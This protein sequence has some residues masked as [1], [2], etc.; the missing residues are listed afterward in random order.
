MEKQ[1]ESKIEEKVPK[2][3]HRS[4]QHYLIDYHEICKILCQCHSQTILQISWKSMK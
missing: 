3:Y 4:A 1:P 2:V